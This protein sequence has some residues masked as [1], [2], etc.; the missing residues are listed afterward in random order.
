MAE[1]VKAYYRM[2]LITAVKSFTVQAQS[3]S[4]RKHQQLS[5]IISPQKL[6]RTILIWLKCLQ[7][8][9]HKKYF[10]NFVQ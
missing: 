8:G 7:V 4:S 1:T 9:I 3:D 10:K 6:A 2:E 5:I